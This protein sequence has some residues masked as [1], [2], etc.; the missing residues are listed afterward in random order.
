MTMHNL[1]TRD[2]AFQLFSQYFQLDDLEQDL[3]D[4]LDVEHSDL[5]TGLLTSKLEEI[6]SKK[7]DK[8]WEID[9]FLN[10]I[11]ESKQTNGWPPFAKG[12]AT[13]G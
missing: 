10:N 3:Q 11:M 12:V 8:Y 7:D 6:S 9:K 4:E 5:I 2:K 1:K 13:N